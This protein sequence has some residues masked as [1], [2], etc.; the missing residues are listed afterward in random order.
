MSNLVKA[1]V[2]LYEIKGEDNP[3]DYYALFERSY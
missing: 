3:D 1:L 2:E